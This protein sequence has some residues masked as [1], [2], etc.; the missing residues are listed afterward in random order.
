M[1]SMVER[2]LVVVG[3][4]V[5]KGQSAIVVTAM[6]M[7]ATLCAPYRGIVLKIN[8]AEGDKVMPGQILIEI[9]KEETDIPPCGNHAIA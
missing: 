6:K 1:P 2:I 9:E 8:V 7:E 4:M 5:E 3:E